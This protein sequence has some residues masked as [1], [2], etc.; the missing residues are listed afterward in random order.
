MPPCRCQGSRP[1]KH[2]IP[3][4]QPAQHSDFRCHTALWCGMPALAKECTGHTRE[5]ASRGLAT[6]VLVCS[7]NGSGKLEFC[8]LVGWTSCYFNS[9]L[10]QGGKRHNLRNYQNVTGSFKRCVLII[11]TIPAR[12]CLKHQ[13]LNIDETVKINRYLN[14]GL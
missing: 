5:T 10:P 8:L 11:N 6:H 14:L 13:D 4:L 7:C 1:H 12:Y 9:F 3:G 2:L